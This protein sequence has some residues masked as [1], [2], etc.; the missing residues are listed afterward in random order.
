MEIERLINNADIIAVATLADDSAVPIIWRARRLVID[1]EHRG[2]GPLTEVGW[3]LVLSSA[4]TLYQRVRETVGHDGGYIRVI[5]GIHTVLVQREHGVSY[6]VVIE[7]GHAVA[8]SLHRTV[9]RCARPI[10]KVISAR[11]DNGVTP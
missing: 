1:G 7:T 2:M 9:R 8:K 4:L 3:E 10:R 11:P 6:G 5:V